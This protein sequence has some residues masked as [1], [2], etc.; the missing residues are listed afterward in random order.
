MSYYSK[1]SATVPLRSGVFWQLSDKWKC[2][3][4]HTSK[5]THQ[6]FSQDG[7]L[8]FVSIYFNFFCP[9]QRG[10]RVLLTTMGIESL[11]DSAKLH[12]KNPSLPLNI[13]PYVFG[14]L[15]FCILYFALS[16]LSHENHVMRGKYDSFPV[17]CPSRRY[18]WKF[19][20]HRG[21]THYSVSVCY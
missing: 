16:F 11:R 20:R 21:C 4:M 15:I 17:S 19:Y 5:S 14:F 2:D 9:I 12:N 6:S 1:S 10:N 7:N 8:T 18:M 13:F 3:T